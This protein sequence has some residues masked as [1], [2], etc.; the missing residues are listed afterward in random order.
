MIYW[1]WRD[2]L[3]AAVD[4][5]LYPEAWLDRRVHEGSARVWGNDQGCIVAEIRTYPSGVR[6]V[7]G[8]VAAGE[9]AAIKALIPEA[10]DW[11]RECGCRRAAIAS[12]PAW[13]RIMRD[14]GY[15]PE[16]LTIAKEL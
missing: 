9:L 11:G 15:E 8:L 3:L 13:A 6:E 16:Q 14:E 7:H 5:E 10:E 1:Q 2:R 4:M 12:H